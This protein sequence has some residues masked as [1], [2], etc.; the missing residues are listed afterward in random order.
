MELEQMKAVWSEMSARLDR[1]QEVTDRMILKMA[2]ERSSSR[3]G[4][5]ILM[6]GIGMVFTIAVLGLLLVRFHELDNWLTITGGVVTALILL[7]SIVMG[8][9]IIR[10]ARRIDLAKNSYQQTLED[11]GALKSLLGLYKKLSIRINLIMPFFLLPVVFQ[12]F[13]GKDL[14]Q[15]FAAYG[16]AL[17]T[18][19]LVTPPLLYLIIRYYRRNMRQVSKAIGEIKDNK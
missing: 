6:E 10:H 3:L 15:D 17:L 9:R 7:L 14:L 16:W 8:G 19:G 5:I 2:H 4:R 12:L 18:C 1:Q 13:L 11:F